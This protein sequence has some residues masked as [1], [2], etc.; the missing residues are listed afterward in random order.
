MWILLDSVLK[1][2]YKQGSDVEDLDQP[3]DLQ[4]DVKDYG[5]SWKGITQGAVPIASSGES[6]RRCSLFYKREGLS[7]LTQVY[8][9]NNILLK[10]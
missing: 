1:S 3:E 2:L 5:E 10:D 4:G 9:L 6:N 8:L 7:T